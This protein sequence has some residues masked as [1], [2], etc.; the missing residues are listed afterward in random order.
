MKLMLCLALISNLTL[1]ACEIYILGKLKRKTDVFKYY[2]YLQN[3]LSLAA[4]AVFVFCLAASFFTG[5]A[6][7]E[8]ARGLRYIST[9]GLLAAML[10][11]TV[12]LSNGKNQLTEED[13]SD[14]SPQKANFILHYFCPLLSLLSFS[15]F[16]RSLLLDHP[17]W[18]SLAAVPSILYWIVYFI[19]SAFKLWKEPYDFSSD[20]KGAVPEAL[21]FTLIPVS[22]IALSFLLWQIK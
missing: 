3:F 12:F 5:R 16:E 15:V 18:T 7:P 10:T 20:K 22:F 6:V 17:V 1:C 21:I 19:L 4:G 2:T 11:Y 13:F 8:F 14:V 9:C